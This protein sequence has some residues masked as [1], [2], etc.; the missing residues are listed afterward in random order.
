MKE[1]FYENLYRP[2]K[3]KVALRCRS[4][5]ATNERAVSELGSK[6]KP[7]PLNSTRRRSESLSLEHTRESTRDTPSIISK[8]HRNSLTIPKVG[9]FQEVSKCCR[10]KYPP[11]SSKNDNSIDPTSQ[12]VGYEQNEDFFDCQSTCSFQVKYSKFLSIFKM[13]IEFRL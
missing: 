5:N 2:S 7:S 9:K 10:S 8:L 6:V 11:R 12:D 4:W 1:K 13:T 3:S